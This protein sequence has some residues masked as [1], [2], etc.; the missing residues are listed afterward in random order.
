MGDICERHLH[1]D[2]TIRKGELTNIPATTIRLD[3]VG[4]SM[5]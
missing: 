4:Q 1:H 2:Q 3:L 5:F